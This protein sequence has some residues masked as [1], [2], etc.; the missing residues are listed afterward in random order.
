[1]H[2]VNEL[3]ATLRSYNAVLEPDG[4]FM[5]TMLGGDTL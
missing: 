4:V 1:M 2:W 3:E 5:G